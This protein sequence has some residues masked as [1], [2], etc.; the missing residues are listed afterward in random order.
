[1]SKRN[2][3]NK[4]IYDILINQTEHI[5]RYRSTFQVYVNVNETIN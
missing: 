3:M 1:M 4:E 2:I 5:H